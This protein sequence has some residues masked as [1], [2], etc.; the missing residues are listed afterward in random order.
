MSKYK[1][2]A[3]VGMSG[4]GKDTLLH[5]ILELNPNVNN[6]VTMTT[7]PPREGETNGV[8]YYFVTDEEFTYRT[9]VTE[10]MLEAT[11][12][13]NWWYGTP[14][15]AL[16]ENQINVGVYNPDG[17]Y[18]LMEDPEIDLTILYV[19][20]NDKI[21]LL[22]CLNREENPN[23][24]EICRRFFADKEQFEKFLTNIEPDFVI[25]NNGE[26]DDEGL[27]SIFS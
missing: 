14:K 8:D 23:C 19:A 3:L 17:I 22:R 26:I 5:Q 11:N 16:K 21:R 1:L 7:R 10:E 9:L 15:F 13:N 4:A 18:C 27:K 2:Y 20:A 24:E 25:D 12:F 6:V